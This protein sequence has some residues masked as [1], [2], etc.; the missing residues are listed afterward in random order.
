MNRILNCGKCGL[1]ATLVLSGF[2]MLLPCVAFAT[3]PTVTTNSA[4]SA[5]ATGATLNGTV[6]PQN[7]ST[8][9]T[10]N[11]GLTTAYG[12]TV[13]ASQSPLAA[14]SGSAPVSAVV[15]GLVCN[16]TYHFQAVGVNSSGTTNGGDLTFTTSSCPFSCTPPANTPAGVTLTCQCDTFTRATLNPSTIFG[17]NW[18]VSTSDATG[19]V[20]SIVNSGYLRLTN[21][22]ASNAKAASV[23]G[24]FPAAG[25]YISVE[26]QQYA[27]N[28]SGADGIAVTLSDYAVPA[29]PGAFGGSLGFAQKSNPGSDCTTPG[30]CPGFAGGWIGVAMDEYG[31]YSAATEGRVLG[32]G[33]TAQSVGVRGPGS[34]QNGYRWMGG[35]LGIG[36]ISNNAS[37]TPA[38][39]NM[40]QVIVDARN[41]ATN[42]I[43]VYVNRDTTTQD[44]TNYTNV[45][46]GA[47]GF[48]AWTEANYALGQGWINSLIPTNWQISF[49]GSTGGAN[50]IHEISRLR[51][52]AQTMVPPSGGSAGSFNAIDS[53]YGTPPAVAVQNYLTGHIYTKLVGTAFNLDVAA[54]SNSQIVTT[55]AAGG[56]KTVTVKLVDNS[57]SLTNSTLDCTLSCTSTCTSKTAVTGGTQ[58]LTFASGATDKGQKQSPNFTLNTAYQKLVA[59]ISDGT[60]SACST[61]SFSVRPLSVA[62]VTSS[63]ATNASASGAP[64]FK[65]GT[66]PFALTATTT[67][68]SGSPSGYTGVMKIN[69]KLV[70][71]NSPATVAGAVAGTFPAATSVIASSSAAGTTFTYSEVGGFT[72]PVNSVYEGVIST[73]DCASLTPAA[74]DALK[75]T[76]WTGVDS[77]SS[78]GDCIA[79]SFSNTLTGG[80]YGCNFG[81]LAAAGPF[82]RFMPDHFDTVV[83]YDVASKA[84]MPCPSGL[85]CPVSG[86][87]P[88]Y[89]WTYATASA[90]TGATGFLSSDIGRLA[91][92]Q[93]DNTTWTLT[94]TTPT[95][96]QFVFVYSGF[97]YSGQPFTT[98][99]TAR[100]ATG[101]TTQNYANTFA[102][103]VTLSAWNAAGGATANPG[104]GALT[105][106]IVLSSAFSAG[107]A[108]TT[109]TAVYTFGTTPTVPTDIYIRAIDTDNITSLQS[110]TSNEGGVK[111]V[112]GRVN[113]GSAY[114]SETL[115][116]TLPAAVQ[117]WTSNGY[118]TSATDIFDL[119]TVA[120]LARSNGTCLGLLLSSGTCS[121]TLGTVSSVTSATTGV[122]SIKL[123]APG[124]GNSGSEYLTVSAGGWPAWLSSTSGL[125][126]FGMYKGANQF[127]Y[128]RESY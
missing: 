93:S 113:V 114:G 81:N 83:K 9:V 66:D 4:T 67:G 118:V 95:W 92:Q 47:G 31:N 119:V 124:A 106:N 69:N 32:P 97:V 117:Y 2:I 10:F 116:L 91:L 75:A 50:N 26:F 57:D 46:G 37:T 12:S 49:T 61:D 58:T 28:G 56:T 5:S 39:G 122:Y 45:F 76:T 52:C 104:G 96:S 43:L 65:A 90:R 80:K 128:Q 3:S 14:N 73:V 34:G 36:N 112:S 71:A 22:T 60:T 107:V 72:L 70:S 79:D 51:I 44:G 33:A 102:K 125:A 109:K 54:L 18:N 126:S 98:Q 123:A 17:A 40:Y 68:V 35:S 85:T 120:N 88:T 77:I 103:A 78:K 110:A 27:Y 11:Y 30:G 62:S 105:S 20:P 64:M 127:I 25:N 6:N 53:A 63:N 94:A 48:N 41:Y 87:S 23:P 86:D 99:V 121:T 7:H 16:T 100:N 21:N 74:C 42:S 108:V 101:A 38:P 15:S 55:Y 29:V 111:V 89:A 115:P 24:I 84:Y 13:T 82:G 1:S 19:I 8:T 59:I